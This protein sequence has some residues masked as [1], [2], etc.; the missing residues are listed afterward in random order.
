M[1]SDDDWE[2]FQKNFKAADDKEAFLKKLSEDKAKKYEK[3]N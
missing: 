3:V 1:N 2:N